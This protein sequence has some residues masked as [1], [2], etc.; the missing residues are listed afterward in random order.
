MDLELKRYYNDLL[1]KVEK[2]ENDKYDKNIMDGRMMY[3]LV[4]GNK[5]ADLDSVVS[6]I[7]YSRLLNLINNT[8]NFDDKNKIY[9]LHLPLINCN[10][11]ELK[12]RFPLITLISYF[13]NNQDKDSTNDFKIEDIPFICLDDEIIS[14]LI[15]EMEKLTNEKKNM[16]FGHYITLVDHNILDTF[17]KNFN[18]RVVS[19][20]DHHQD[21]MITKS[22]YRLSL[23]TKIG[24]C[25]TL[26]G[27]IWRDAYNKGKINKQTLIENKIF[28]EMII[29]TI[30]KD[31]CNFDSKLSE[32]RWSSLDLE[33]YNWILEELSLKDNDKKNNKYTNFYSNFLKNSNRNV[34]LIFNNRPIELFKMDYKDFVYNKKSDNKDIIVGYSSFEIDLLKMISHYSLENFQSDVKKFIISNNLNLF[35]I[36]S[37]YIYIKEDQ[38]EEVKKQIVISYIND[39]IHGLDIQNLVIKCLES[40]LQ[41][42]EIKV[43]SILIQNLNQTVQSFA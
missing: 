34:D 24:S 36:L 32:K 28:L 35:I 22:K 31:T 17:H 33:V 42:T 9:G 26:I 39:H 5:S 15:L 40:I 10:K 1:N 2:K 25:T 19:I 6:A 12:L 30:L 41:I 7:T 43:E 29:C 37:S 4:I 27:K 11:N 8:I 23:G 18:E 21:Y 14:E 3:N 16:N 13:S 38:S 20:V